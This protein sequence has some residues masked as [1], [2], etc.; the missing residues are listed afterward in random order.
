[1]RHFLLA[2]SVLDELSA[3]L[4]AAVL[5]IEGPA[6]LIEQVR[7]RNLFAIEFEGDVNRL[8]YH[9]LFRDFLQSCL[10]REDETSF[11]QL[12][13]RAA[14]AYASRGEWERAVSRYLTLGEYEPVTDIVEGT[15]GYLF[16]VG[17][18]DTLA[19][20]IDAL[21]EAIRN[22]KPRLLVERAKI[23]TERGE[24]TPALALFEQA[25]RAFTITGDTASA[26]HL[27][28]RKGILLRYQGRYA[29]AIGQ[30]QQALALTSGDTAEERS[31]MALA[32]KNLGLCWL[33]LGR[34]VKGRESLHQALHLYEEMAASHDMGMVQHD[35]GLDYEL[36]GD[37]TG[38]VDHY[39][40]ALGYWQQLGNLSTWANT[41]NSLGV[42]YLLQGK[43]DQALATLN[44]ALARAQQAQDQRIEAFA[45]AS[46]GDLHRDLGAY[47]LARG[48]YAQA[49]AISRRTHAGFVITYALDGLGNTARLQGDLPQ[50]RKRLA[51]ALEVAEDH[52]SAYESGLCRTSLGIVASAEGNLAAA[53]GHLDQA[54]EIL[55]ASDLQ[56][57]LARTCLHRAQT[58]FLAGERKTA[59]VDLERALGLTDQLGFD[60]FLVVE[61]QQLQ[62]M[63]RYAAEQE[64]RSDVLPQLLE[65]IEAHRGRV[66]ERPEPAVRAEPQPTLKIYALGQSEVEVDGQCL[67]WTVAKSRD[68]FF[69]LLQHPQG[70]RKEQIG[71]VFWPD[72]GPERLD[73]AFRSTLY[74]LRRTVFRDGVVFE[75]G[76]YRFNRASD[77]RFDVEAFEGLLHQAEGTAIP[78]EASA[79]LEE[80]L[81]LYRGD[82]LPG[83]Y[84]DWSALERERLRGRYQ[85]V[86]E[87]LAGLYANRRNLQRAVELY[88]RLLSE[89]PYREGAYREL[90]HCYYRLG[91]R[92]AAI[93]QYQTCAEILREELGLSP[94]AETEAL[95]MQIIG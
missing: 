41:L 11:R 44:E 15:A 28:A 10:R 64:V 23:H 85:A 76:L 48:A 19:G 81:A 61:G 14:K 4:C 53:R 94:A 75:D 34:L 29:E 22:T 20:W 87:T 9:D 79:L 73:S 26:A 52:G 27:L 56:H 12:T 40:A 91:D 86:L 43:Y 38:A 80:A 24:H 78:G 16:G 7:R 68:L 36:A 58:A 33:R 69:F 59:L 47:E 45:F 70:Q 65:R 83:I 67:Q 55:E 60:Q 84:A 93:R 31:A 49:L 57:Q 35:L 90:M 71:A 3:E 63:L 92:A 21:P 77:Y 6:D 17:R 82:Y 89:N 2:S 25:E 39:Q 30:C 5:G 88:Q 51:E 46:L 72:H 95:Y 37:L 74:R 1:L 13:R 18:W 8:R 62:P 42:V 32:H 66:A 50:A 54:V